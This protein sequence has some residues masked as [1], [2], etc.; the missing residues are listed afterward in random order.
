MLKMISKLDQLFCNRLKRII[1]R[2]IF[3]AGIL[4][5]KLRWIKVDHKQNLKLN[6]EQ[7]KWKQDEYNHLRYDWP[8]AGKIFC[9]LLKMRRVKIMGM[10]QRT[11]RERKRERLV[12]SS[13]PSAIPTLEPN[14]SEM[15][16]LNRHNWTNSESFPSLPTAGTSHHMY[17][18]NLCHFISSILLT[19]MLN[20]LQLFSSFM[21]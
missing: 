13:P 6:E 5:R 18:L 16:I 1:F 3:D 17:P 11:T 7:N 20:S 12:R 2:V 8:L 15:Y 4:I 14:L 19:F 9:R 10:T 21:L